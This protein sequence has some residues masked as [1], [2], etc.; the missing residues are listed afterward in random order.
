M[1]ILVLFLQTKF[2]NDYAN[3]LAHIQ[4]LNYDYLIFLRERSNMAGLPSENVHYYKD[5]FFNF[6]DI[7]VVVQKYKYLL[8]L[9][10]NLEINHNV[11]QHL[12]PSIK[13]LDNNADI[14][15]VI[16]Q[17]IDCD[18]T[19][20]NIS[21]IQVR[22]PIIKNRILDNFNIFHRMTAFNNILSSDNIKNPYTPSNL[23]QFKHTDQINS[24]VPFYNFRILHSLLRIS[25]LLWE[26]NF[27][28]NDHFE[29]T[30]SE[31]LDKHSF[32]TCYLNQPSQMNANNN[33]IV[34]NTN[35]SNITIVTAF[36]NL[37]LPR[38]HKR[39]SQ[40]Y[41]YLEKAKYTLALH[42]CMV[43]YVT[44]DLIETV[45]NFRNSIG[46]SDKTRIIEVTPET[47][48][49]LYNKIDVIRNNVTKNRS[50][51]NVAE[52][53]LAVN[54]R[55]D[56]VKDAIK[57]NYLD[58][59]YFAWVDFAAGHIVD[60]PPTFKITY[61]KIDKI[62]LS[63]IGRIRKLRNTFVF[64][65]KCCGGGVFVGHKTMMLEFIKLHDI[66]FQKLMN[67]GYCINDDKLLF[68]IFEKYPH[69]FDIY[70]CGYKSILTNA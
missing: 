26:D 56:L 4:N 47:H 46:L 63:R 7:K 67:M 39:E 60:I 9:D 64:D 22:F 43:I 38:K 41:D 27:I 1:S 17:N 30:Y 34:D 66:E 29:Y 16:F 32:L 14:D 8:Y 20:K 62:R 45:H 36:I 69:L 23:I 57:N 48:L 53:I 12:L 59:D 65:H 70:V 25:K 55:Y 15:Q 28:K 52:Y 37:N 51:Y 44:S 3:I 11:Q 5:P 6:N 50:P 49:Y 13:I 58:T 21:G 33:I 35:G 18:F 54:S 31:L 24:N 42:Q 61:S 2:S 40:Q 10:D 68:M 19:E